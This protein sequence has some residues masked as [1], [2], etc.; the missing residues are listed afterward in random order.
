MK[1]AF[2][3]LSTQRLM[4]G[5]CRYYKNVISLLAEIMPDWQILNWV[6]PENQINYS[7]S[8]NNYS[9]FL[10]GKWAAN[11]NFRIAF[12]QTFMGGVINRH[13]PDLFHGNGF[14]PAGLRC[15]KVVTI[16]D[17]SYY[18]HPQRTTFTR[19][20]YFRE[21]SRIAALRADIII[22]DSISS[23]NDIEKFI[24]RAAGK[25][26]VAPIGTEPY[27]KP[28]NDENILSS[29][30]K[31]HG[32]KND[33]FLYLGTLEPGK[34]LVRLIRAYAQAIREFKISSDLIIAGKRGWLFE[35]I[36]LEAQ[37]TGLYNKRIFFADFISENELPLLYNSAKCLVFPSLNEGFGLPPLEAMSC[38]TPVITSNCSSLP[39]VVGD[40]ALLIDPY[41]EKDI[42]R[43]MVKIET[44][45]EC[46][47]ELKKKSVKQAARFSL[48]TMIETIIDIYKELL[49]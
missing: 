23:K 32:F 10:L 36:F 38:G 9:E 19:S 41:S 24:P 14:I 22:T 18:K 13:K 5:S 29:F 16:H 6:N 15:K 7:F 49:S 3:A 42:C 8:K 11:R 12:E 2:N 37:K 33:F 20:L 40:A 35:E 34:N 27:F 21:F 17:M 4:T 30:R 48:K 25:I 43:A 46:A 39:E 28:I 47:A 26:R 45:K 31:T 44:D 1:I